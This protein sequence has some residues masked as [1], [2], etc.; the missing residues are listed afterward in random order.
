MERLAFHRANWSHVRWEYTQC[1]AH[2]A[3]LQLQLEDMGGR[4]SWSFPRAKRWVGDQPNDF[5]G[6][7]KTRG[8]G[9]ISPKSIPSRPHTHTHALLP[10]KLCGGAGAGYRVPVPSGLKM[11]ERV[12]RL[13]KADFIPRCHNALPKIKHQRPQ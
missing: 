8:S 7:P 3:P 9:S 1:S 5:D 11:S 12:R 2:P 13:G 10:L 6:S 4:K